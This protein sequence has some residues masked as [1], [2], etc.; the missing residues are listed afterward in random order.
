MIRLLGQAG[1]FGVAVGSPARSINARVSAMRFEFDWDPAKAAS[2]PVFL[3]PLALSKPDED[4]SIGEERWVTM[5]QGQDAK[6]LAV[7]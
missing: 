3:D 1:G 2:N 7:V 5:G 6:L 4:S